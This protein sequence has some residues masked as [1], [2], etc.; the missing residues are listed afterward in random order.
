[1]PYYRADWLLPISQPPIRDGW[2]LTDRGRVVAFGHSRPGDMTPAGEIDLGAV[3]V[4]PGLVNAHTHL[5]LSWLRGRIRETDDF[6]GWIRS[7][8]S[9]IRSTDDHAEEAEAAIW[10]GIDEAVQCGTVLVGDISNR[11]V[12]SAPLAA[13]GLAALVFHELIDFKAA[14]A[15]K[16]VADGLERMKA[17]P[18][19]E[20]LRHVLA[21][22]APY[23]VSPALFEA[24]HRERNG[25]VRTSV[26]LGESTAEV[27]FLN[28]GTGP[29]RQFLEDINEWD[30]GWTIPACGPVEY[31]DRLGF[32]DDRLVVVHG[33]QFTR[34]ELQRIAAAGA[35]LVTCPRGNLRTGAGMPPVS[36]FYWEGV[37][38][39]VGTDSLASVPDLNVFSE[40]AELRRLA[41]D[42]PARALLESATINGARALGFETD[43]GS[44]DAGKCDALLAIAIPSGVKDVEEYLV[45]GIAPSQVRWLPPAEK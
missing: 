42:V 5:E 3:A 27:E 36:D 13:R 24:I 35:T 39:A 40:L 7:V 38:V 30:N 44:I 33:V 19:G 26:H 23:S 1:M 18:S 37:R 45:S 34:A 2:I 11:L 21:P 41:P 32:I 4:L 22:H 16:A 8:V 15:R 28:D 12:S 20:R 14:N 17:V 10:R 31:L 9:L 6:P 25:V 29:W 43:F